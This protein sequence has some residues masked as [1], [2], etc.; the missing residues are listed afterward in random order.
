M[1]LPPLADGQE[2]IGIIIAIP[3]PW[4]TQ[5]TDLR[6]SL[7]DDQANRVPAHI[8][9][10][11][12]TAVNTSDREALIH[13]LSSIAQRHRA[14]TITL[15]G[16]DSFRPVS[17]V[18]F[19]KVEGGAQECIELAEDIRSGIL[20]VDLRFPYHPHVTLAHG[21]DDASLDAALDA[22]TDFEASWKVPGFRLDRVDA[23]G[24]YSSMALFDFEVN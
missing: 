3:E 10:L 16:S 19:V 5:L 23:T 9:L 13:H 18:A 11:P 6:R 21:L 15:R 7:G 1:Y 4:V 2:W 20:D 22:T 17:P 14:F 24:H 8:T 12:P